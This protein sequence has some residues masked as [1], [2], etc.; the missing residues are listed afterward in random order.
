MANSPKPLVVIGGPIHPAGVELLGREAAVAI[1]D[2]LTE[3]GVI[4]AAREAQ[5]LLLRIFIP[6]TERLMASCPNLKCVGRYGVGLDNVDLASATRL[7]IPIVHAPGSNSDS[8]AEHTVMLVLATVKKLIPIDRAMRLGEWRGEHSR[9][10]SELK[11]A[12]LGIIGVG[13]IGRRVARMARSFGMK[14]LGF[15]PYVPPDE[16]R[17]RD[18]E[19][20]QNL[21]ELLAAS[22][23]VTCHTPLTDETRRMINAAAI[24]Q[25]KDGAVL[26]NTSRGQVVDEGALLA[27][28]TNGKLRAAGLDVW[29][30]EPVPASHP[31]LKLENVV[32]T[33][34]VAGMSEA[35]N[36]QMALGVASEIL[37]VLRGEKPKV[38][39]NP[40]LWARLSHLR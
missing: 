24:G 10:I 36:R 27:A 5:A 40:D 28:L 8:A 35:A 20:V 7:G 34:H 13:N 4:K 6:C 18:V 21:G 12:T 23:I 29:E 19:P 16:L 25:M 30:E 17:R 9:G 14:T 39:G 26:I 2:D 1:A 37:R 22:D 15:D 11:G 33:P 32:T 3:D 38:L 31:L